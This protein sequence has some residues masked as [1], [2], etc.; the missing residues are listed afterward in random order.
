M[1]NSNGPQLIKTDFIG[2]YIILIRRGVCHY[3]I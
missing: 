1:D 3:D 2:V